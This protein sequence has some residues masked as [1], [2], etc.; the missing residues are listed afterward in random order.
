MPLLPK[1][2]QEMKDNLSPINVYVFDAVLDGRDENFLAFIIFYNIHIIGTCL[3]DIIQS[4]KLDRKSV[5]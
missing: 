4:A 5:V 2:R 3:K 1:S